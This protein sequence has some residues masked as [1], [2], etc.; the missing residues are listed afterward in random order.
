MPQS[1]RTPGLDGDHEPDSIALTLAFASMLWRGLARVGYAAMGVIYVTI[2]VVA[3]RIAFLG[4]RGHVAGM[5]GALAVLLRQEE[6]RAIVALVAAGLA[7]FAV[8]RTVQTFT[9]RGGAIAR[10]GWAITAI[11]YG[12]L[13]WTGASLLLKF[14]RGERF[15]RMGVGTLLPYPAGRF[16]LR[17]AA[18]ILLITGIIAVVQ[19]MSGRLPRWLAGAGFHRPARGIVWRAARIGLAARGIVAIA[20]GY[21]LL[22]AVADFDPREAV[23][24]G[25][26]LRVLSRSPGG[27]ILMGVVALGLISYGIA[28]WAVAA[29]RRP[30]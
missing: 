8:W 18:A 2:G 20:M 7:C 25:G 30:A 29:A 27:P 12:A 1:L 15:E 6:G 11:G 21:L 5:H 24:I 22:R 9:A 26:S 3:A 14:P 28:L 19:G 16:A 10:A 23:E 4:T 13:A 17:L